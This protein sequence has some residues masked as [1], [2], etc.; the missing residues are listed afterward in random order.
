MKHVD[1][2]EKIWEKEKC[3]KEK[4]NASRIQRIASILLLVPEEQQE[5]VKD[6][7]A[8]SMSCSS[9]WQS[10]D[11]PMWKSRK[12][13]AKVS[14]CLGMTVRPVRGTPRLRQSW[15]ILLTFSEEI[16]FLCLKMSFSTDKY[17]Y[18]HADTLKD[19]FRLGW[20]SL[21]TIFK[22]IRALRVTKGSNFYWEWVFHWTCTLR[23]I[24]ASL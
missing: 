18:R 12:Q 13:M 7:K 20:G 10:G 11:S 19:S 14:R 4:C 6:D 15:C 2:E 8:W 24:L 16:F 3:R 1:Y 21:G 5:L 9:R 17:C 23:T 22:N